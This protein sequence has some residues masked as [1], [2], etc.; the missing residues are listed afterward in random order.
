MFFF[1]MGFIVIELYKPSDL[2][3]KP[4]GFYRSKDWQILAR[5]NNIGEY[6]QKLARFTK[7]GVH[8]ICMPFLFCCSV[9]LEHFSFKLQVKH[10][11]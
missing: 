4:R 8:L 5:F 7:I 11:L 3:F 6:S 1:V 9:F 2:S 10:S